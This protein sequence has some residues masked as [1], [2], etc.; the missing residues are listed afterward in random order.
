MITK[1]KL[2]KFILVMAFLIT[3]ITITQQ[4][5]TAFSPQNCSSYV[6]C[7]IQT[8]CCC[9]DGQCATKAGGGS[10][11]CY[12]TDCGGSACSTNWNC[13][14]ENTVCFG[15]GPPYVGMCG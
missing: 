13:C 1:I 10:N 15:G 4:P 9:T 14:M 7:G 8:G 6:S 11:I 2:V 5:I 12:P 3:N